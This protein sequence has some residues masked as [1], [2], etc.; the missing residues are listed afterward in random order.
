VRRRCSYER[1]DVIKLRLLI[2]FAVALTLLVCS[3]SVAQAIAAS[4]LTVG[5]RP[6]SHESGCA[7]AAT[8]T[9]VQ[10]FVRNYDSGRVATIDRLWAPEPR[11]QWFST[12]KPGARIGS[13]AYD[14]AALAAYFRARVR[15][16]ERLRLPKLGAGYDPGRKIVNF[17]GKL[18]R[19][20]DDI[21][22]VKGAADCVSGR[23]SL[24]V[25]SM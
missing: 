18:V 15:V 20:A 23:P 19:S 17:A 14:R 10:N 12:G 3:G 24:I 2:A 5:G 1:W 16:H 6:L 9:L 22:P 21:R 4:T 25:W 7:A 13:R 11:F 8:K